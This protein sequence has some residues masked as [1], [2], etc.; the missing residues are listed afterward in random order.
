MSLTLTG[1]LLWLNKIDMVHGCGSRHF[2]G[3]DE[4]TKKSGLNNIDLF[5]DDDF[6][7]FFFLVLL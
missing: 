7:F 5:E 3:R 1:G 2:E 6:E 4:T